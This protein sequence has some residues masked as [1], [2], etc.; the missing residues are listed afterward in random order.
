MVLALGFFVYSL[1]SNELIKKNN[2]IKI[3]NITLSFTHIILCMTIYAIGYFLNYDNI[4][5]S[6]ICANTGGFFMNEIVLIVK[7][8]NFSKTNLALIVHHLMVYSIIFIASF[9]SNLYF[10]LVGAE[11]TNLP[12]CVMY[13]FIQIKKEYESIGSYYDIPCENMIK[14]TQAIIYIGIRVFVS[15]FYIYKSISN[16]QN[17]HMVNKCFYPPIY[18]IGFIWSYKLYKN[19]NKKKIKNN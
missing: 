10:I 9:R 11:F 6:L 13:Y 19:L 7:T 3:T 5:K 4:S 17:I 16:D 8:R 1:I 14:Y 12:G 2:N 15:P 18:L